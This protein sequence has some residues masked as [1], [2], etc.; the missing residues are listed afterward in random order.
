LTSIKIK[1]AGCVAERFSQ[2]RESARSNKSQK[3]VAMQDASSKEIANARL[4]SRPALAASGAVD[5]LLSVR[6]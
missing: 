4:P 3:F 5:L 2:Q 6:D 1:R